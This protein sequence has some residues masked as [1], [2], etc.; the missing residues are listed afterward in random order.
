MANVSR[1]LDDFLQAGSQRR[2]RPAAFAAED[3]Q[4]PGSRLPPLD[5]SR[6]LFH[7]FDSLVEKNSF[8]YCL[9]LGI[10]PVFAGA[11]MCNSIQVLAAFTQSILT[12][13]N[14]SSQQKFGAA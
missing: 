8:R 6:L 5:G 11:P 9:V 10:K 1:P 3:R 7:Y 12:T 2:G 14:S 4:G 13:K